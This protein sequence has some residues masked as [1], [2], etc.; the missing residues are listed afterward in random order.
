M[1]LIEANS[2]DEAWRLA[3]DALH[4]GCNGGRVAT[5][6]EGP[7]KVVAHVEDVA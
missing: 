4:Q 2:A 1:P 3:V 7:L 5:G 6:A